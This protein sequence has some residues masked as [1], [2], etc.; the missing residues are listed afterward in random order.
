MIQEEFARNGPAIY[1]SM[2]EWLGADP[3]FTPSFEVV[4]PAKEVRSRRFA[5]ALARLNHTVVPALGLRRL[6]RSVKQPLTRAFNAARRANSR[7]RA[8]P[9]DPA[10]RATLVAKFAGDERDRRPRSSGVVAVSRRR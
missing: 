6:P 2:V 1:R 8:P 3:A 10:L 7:R 4:N 9:F 5:A